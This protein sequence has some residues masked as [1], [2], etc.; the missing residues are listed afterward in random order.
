MR[1]HV[2][3]V[4]KDFATVDMH[5]NAV[6]L[7]DFA[8][9]HLLLSFVRYA[10]CPFCGLRIFYLTSRYPALQA[11]GLSIVAVTESTPANAQTQNVLAAAPFAVIPD[12]QHHLFREYGV[13]ISPWGVLWGEIKRARERIMGQQQGLAGGITGNIFRMPADFLIRPDGTIAVAHYGKE[14]GDHLPFA[15]VEAWLAR[16]TQPLSA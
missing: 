15:E 8:G 16:Q 9:K 2:G 14:I 13:S 6:Q 11:K 10:G 3:Q 12:P 7:Q 5:G 4:A 1:L